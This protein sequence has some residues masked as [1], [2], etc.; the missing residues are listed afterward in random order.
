MYSRNLRLTTRAAERLAQLAAIRKI[1]VSCGHVKS[2]CQDGTLLARA[3][4]PA[5]GI[6]FKR[7][8]TT[9]AASFGLPLAPAAH[10]A[11]TRTLYAVL[12]VYGALHARALQ[13]WRSELGCPRR[14]SRQGSTPLHGRALVFE[15]ADGREC[16]ADRGTRQAQRSH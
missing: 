13:A 6:T 5:V 16:C 11:Q 3:S 15:S 10:S 12:E 1:A 2:E 9:L 4:G 7:S 14:A 8:D